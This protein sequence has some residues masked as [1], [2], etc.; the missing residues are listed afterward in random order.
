MRPHVQRTKRTRVAGS[1][2][3]YQSYPLPFRGAR[4]A[5][6]AIKKPPKSR[7]RLNRGC[8]SGLQFCVHPGAQDALRASEVNQTT[9]GAMPN[10]NSHL[11]KQV[12]IA[13]AYRQRLLPALQMDV[14]SFVR[15]ARDMTDR[16]QVDHHRAMHLRE[17]RG[18][19]LGK[20]LLE[21]G[22]NHRLARLSRVIAPGDLR[23]LLLGA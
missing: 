7:T 13:S 22:A 5:V 9:S 8:R 16:T 2:G 19:E 17:L 20:E 6:G 3:T 10:C 18:I 4:F 1:D 14:R 12:Q 21:R 15:A 11:P 23:V